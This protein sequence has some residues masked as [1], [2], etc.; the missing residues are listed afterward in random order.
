MSMSKT[1]ILSLTLA[2]IAGSITV[3]PLAAAEQALKRTDLVKGDV[4]AAGYEVVQVLV[5]FA[6]GQTAGSHHHPGVEIAHVTKGTL[7]YSLQGKAPVIVKTGQSLYIPSGVV[8][9]VRNVGDGEATELAT[10]IARK[11]ETLLV[12]VK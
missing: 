5:G 10:Y 8:H 2:L 9:S 6:P 3:S 4:D 11:G 7:E 12:P 1:R